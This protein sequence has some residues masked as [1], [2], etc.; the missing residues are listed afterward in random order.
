MILLIF[1]IYQKRCHIFKEFQTGFFFKK[2]TLWDDFYSFE[3]PK[4]IPRL[5]HGFITSL[6]KKTSRKKKKITPNF[7]YIYW[8]VVVFLL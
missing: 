1:L 7:S 6:N 4:N 5:N 3:K 8:D 2:E